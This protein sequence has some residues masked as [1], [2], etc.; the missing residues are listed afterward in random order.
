VLV[1]QVVVRVSFEV[2]FSK[3]TAAAGGEARARVLTLRHLHWLGA[4]EVGEAV[5]WPS[6]GP[7]SSV[8]VETVG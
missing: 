2:L 1:E 4:W 6:L 3:T 7:L 5:D 8:L